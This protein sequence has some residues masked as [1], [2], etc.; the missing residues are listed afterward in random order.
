MGCRWMLGIEDRTAIMAGLEAGLSQVCVAHLIGRSPSVVRHEI[1]RHT[2][3]DG[4]YWAKS[5][6]SRPRSQASP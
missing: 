1:V 5:W 2:G 6:Q 3:P 4:E